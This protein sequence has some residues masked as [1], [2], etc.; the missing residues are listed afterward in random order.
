MLLFLPFSNKL[1]PPKCQL[2]GCP[3]HQAMDYEKRVTL[4]Q[5]KA[6]VLSTETTK[7]LLRERKKSVGICSLMNGNFPYF[8]PLHPVGQGSVRLPGVQPFPAPA[9]LQALLFW[10]QKQMLEVLLQH[11]SP[12]RNTCKL[13]APTPPGTGDVFSSSDVT[14][15]LAKYEATPRRR[16]S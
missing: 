12:V 5:S 7:M 15:G 3:N 6:A 2:G 9:R 10:K 8:F 1:K 16:Q 13:S 11:D 14:E 4:L